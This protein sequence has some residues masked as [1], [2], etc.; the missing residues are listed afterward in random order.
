MLSKII[1][2]TLLSIVIMTELATG[3]FGQGDRP[4]YILLLIQVH[5]GIDRHI[6]AITRYD[7][8]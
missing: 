7:I 1:R 4:S 5:P 2:S 8:L 6:V 3:C